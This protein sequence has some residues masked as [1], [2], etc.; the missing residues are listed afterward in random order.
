MPA[1]VQTQHLNQA[2]AQTGAMLMALLDALQSIQ[3]NGI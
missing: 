3:D 2:V 1:L